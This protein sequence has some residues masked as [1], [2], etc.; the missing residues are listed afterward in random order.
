[1]ERVVIRYKDESG[2]IITQGG[3]R[4]TTS[5]IMAREFK[6]Y[7][8]A[9]QYIEDHIVISGGLPIQSVMEQF[10]IVNQT[11]SEA[12]INPIEEFFADISDDRVISCVRYFLFDQSFPGGLPHIQTAQEVASLFKRAQSKKLVSNVKHFL[13]EANKEYLRRNNITSTADESEGVSDV[14][15]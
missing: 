5:P 12:V 13:S 11:I 3:V 1:M 7:L 15:S 6:S 4:K 9:Y 2:Y 10:D 8:D 14:K